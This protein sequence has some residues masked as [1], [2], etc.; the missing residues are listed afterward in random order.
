MSRLTKNKGLIPGVPAKS[1]RLS[2]RAAA[3]WDRLEAEL[4]KSGKKTGELRTE[5]DKN[6]PDKVWVILQKTKG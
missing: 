2:V 4:I 5:A 1:P 6:Y 3:E